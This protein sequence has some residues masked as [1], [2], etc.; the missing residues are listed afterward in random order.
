MF[1]KLLAYRGVGSNLFWITAGI[2]LVIVI[3][4]VD[5]LTGYEAS[6]SIFYILPIA[7]VSWFS[8]KRVGYWFCGLCAIVWLLADLGSGHVYSNPL[9]PYWNTSVRL[10]FFLIIAVT[11]SELRV[12]IDREVEL[13]RRD[14]VTGLANRRYFQELVEL[15]LSQNTSPDRP[16]TLVYLQWG[17]LTMVNEQLGF[18]I[19]DQ[20]LSE[21][22]EIIKQK[23]SRHDLVGRIGSAQFAMCLPN[24]ALESA[25]PIITEVVKDL[26][27]FEKQRGRG[28]NFWVAVL[29]CISQPEHVEALFEEVENL[30]QTAKK[31][32]MGEPKFELVN[33]ASLGRRITR[34]ID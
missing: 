30:L 34:R 8:N 32:D 27:L 29:T 20:T 13:A 1:E 16:L 4:S 9:I 7:T 14:F 11:L 5:L 12:R 2:S 17:A 3:G 21:I 33:G 19:G 15:E 10:G 31:S 25:R 24:T 23:A 22:G 26:R 18:T 28:A 6:F